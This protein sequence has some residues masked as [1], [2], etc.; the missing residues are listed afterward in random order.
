MEEAVALVAADVGVP[1]ALVQADRAHA[2]AFFAEV[3][4]GGDPARNKS[5]AGK[6]DG[7]LTTSVS[8]RT[9]KKWV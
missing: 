8:E 2:Q 3:K 4:L 6:V 1:L 9:K 7:T 5:R